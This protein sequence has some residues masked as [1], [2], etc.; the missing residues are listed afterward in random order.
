[1]IEKSVNLSFNLTEFSAALA[2]YTNES[3]ERGVR[4]NVSLPGRFDRVKRPY[5]DMGMWNFRSL[6]ASA[7]L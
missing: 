5:K 4:R 3:D 2:P 7:A 1:M 6:N